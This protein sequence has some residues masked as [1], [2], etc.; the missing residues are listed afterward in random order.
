MRSLDE[1]KL[2]GVMLLKVEGDD[3]ILQVLNS[4]YQ[5]KLIETNKHKE[6]REILKD[7]NGDIRVLVSSDLFDLF[8][9]ELLCQKLTPEVANKLQNIVLINILPYIATIAKQEDSSILIQ[10]TYS[11][12]NQ[13][14]TM[15][16]GLMDDMQIL[17]LDI[18]E[19]EEK[20]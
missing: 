20:C 12:K 13:S 11:N 1:L 15:S 7:F 18:H 8:N 3:M 14:L 10:S 2:G 16:I 17:L 5:T 6:L 19:K 4:K 9:D